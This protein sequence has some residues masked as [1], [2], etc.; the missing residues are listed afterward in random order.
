[1]KRFFTWFAGLFGMVA[2][3][4]SL[5]WMIPW[6]E[7]LSSSGRIGVIEIHGTIDSSQDTLKAI[8]QFRKEADVK[9]IIVR[10]DSPGGAIGPSQEIY[11]E[12]R[13]TIP[14]KPVI[15]S[16]GSVAASGGYYIASAASHIVSNPGTITGSIGVIIFFPNLR[17]LFGKIGYDM[18]TLK[19]GKVQGRG[20]SGQGND[21]G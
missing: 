10:I 7:F 21:L 8:K 9:A 4:L 17:E 1:M 18:V 2:I 11:R 14:E 13:R 6:F 15:A 19:A 20:Q 5:W 16:L 3:G 12:I